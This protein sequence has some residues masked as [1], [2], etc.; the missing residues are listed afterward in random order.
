MMS[1]DILKYLW[2]TASSVTVPSIKLSNTVFFKIYS[3]LLIIWYNKLAC[4]P[5]YQCE[6][7]LS[8]CAE[9]TKKFYSTC[10][11]FFVQC[12]LMNR[13]L[14][15]KKS[16]FNKINLAA[17]VEVFKSTRQKLRPLLLRKMTRLPEFWY[18]KLA[19]LVV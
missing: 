1:W 16:F 14:F 11:W 6:N 13:K 9:Y 4:C 15:Q 17:F 7:I 12:Y 19:F 3:I 5:F 2:L 18:P 10:F 8:Q